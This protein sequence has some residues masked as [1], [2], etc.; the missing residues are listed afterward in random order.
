MTHQNHENR[1]ICPLGEALQ[2]YWDKLSG[3]EQSMKID[4][5]GLYSMDV[6]AVAFATAQHIES[7]HIV[8]ACCGIGGAAIA[9]ARAGK[10][11]TAIEIDTT[12]LRMAEHNAEIFGVSGMIEFV[13][14]D[15]RSTLG[16]Y[17]GSAVYLDPP[18]GGPSYGKLDKFKLN[19]FTPNGESFLAP[20]LESSSE[21]V[22][23]LPKNFDFSEFDR[24]RAPSES[25][26]N[27]LEGKLQYYTAFFRA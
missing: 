13:N 3:P 27:M 8:D 7:E 12:R 5:E 24:F 2:N 16:Q 1:S 11:V 21:V 23:K 20:A 22:F 4:L 26:E 15:A 14:G 19:H 25:I 17:P 10:R 6:Q 9:F 18:W